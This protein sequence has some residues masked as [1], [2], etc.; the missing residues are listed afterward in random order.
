LTDR[1]GADRRI[2]ERF[3]RSHMLPLRGRREWRPS[4]PGPDS[5]ATSYWVVRTVAALRPADFELPFDD[6]S[7]IGHTLDSRWHGTPLAGLGS[8]FARL[9]AR[10]RGREQKKDVSSSVYEMF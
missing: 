4:P 8:R 3:L 7:E 10:F 1:A 2:L 6:A 5:S 9:A